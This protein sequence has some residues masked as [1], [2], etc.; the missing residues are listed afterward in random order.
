M[1]H[2]IVGERWIQLIERLESINE[3]DVG[4][5]TNGLAEFLD[6]SW[7]QKPEFGSEVMEHNAFHFEFRYGA[8]QGATQFLIFDE[9]E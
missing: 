9:Y 7:A 5:L 4:A 3:F 1:V 6:F 8:L 2:V